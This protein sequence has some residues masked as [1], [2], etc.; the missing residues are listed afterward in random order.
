MLNL[1]NK[2]YIAT[3]QNNAV[4][5]AK[6]YGLGLEFNNTCI[7]EILDFQNRE[8]LLADMKKD[9]ENVGFGTA[10]LHGPFTE[11]HPAAIDYRARDLAMVRIEEAYEVCE[12]LGIKKM[13]VHTGWIPFIYFKEWQAQKGADFWQK[14]MK[15][16]PDDFSICVENVLDDE[17]Y[18]LADMMHRIE[19]HRIKLCLDIGHAN[20][21]TS[22]EIPVEDWI[23]ELGP[24][25]SHFHLHN[26][27]QDNDT[28]S[29][30]NTGSMDMDAVF[31]AIEKHCADDV[32]FTI[33]ARECENC[34][35]WLLERGY[36]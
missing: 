3:F 15:D 30:F 12:A 29:D 4:E 6:N 33:E 1:K 13:V 27:Y 17:P 7:S 18:M 14:F 20:A 25:I 11:I 35:K 5:V 26:N 28:H 22:K 34:V 2:L 10:V 8:K 24:Y 19:D 23:K 31:E 9:F 16:K 36:I 21:V 32:T